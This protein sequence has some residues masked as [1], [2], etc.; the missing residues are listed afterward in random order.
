[1][2]C[3]RCGELLTFLMERGGMRILLCYACGTEHHAL[4][5]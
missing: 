2:R 3:V 1:M 5:E 4:I